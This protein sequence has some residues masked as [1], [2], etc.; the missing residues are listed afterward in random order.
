MRLYEQSLKLA[1][2]LGDKAGVAS[3]L[4]QL[5][6]VQQEQGNYAEARAPV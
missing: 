4:H 5:G 3:S 1:E 6:M 2:A